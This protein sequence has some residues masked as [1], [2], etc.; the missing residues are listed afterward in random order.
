VWNCIGGKLVL[1]ANVSEKLTH[2]SKK[3]K[4]IP[5]EII[6]DELTCGLISIFFFQFLFVHVS[7]SLGCNCDLPENLART[8]A[9]DS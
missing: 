2:L 1:I 4:Q 8:V 3:E 9:V 7:V 5:M 6:T